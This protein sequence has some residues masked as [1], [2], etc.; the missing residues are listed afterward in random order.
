MA[1]QG[2]PALFVDTG[3]DAPAH[4]NA[5]RLSN[6]SKGVSPRMFAVGTVM[7]GTV[8]VPATPSDAYLMQTDFVQLSFS[9]GS[10]AY[11]FPRAFPNGVATIQLTTVHAGSLGNPLAYSN[12]TLTGFTVWLGTTASPWYISVLAIGW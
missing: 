8:P 11:T 12:I 2:I 3:K 6:W 4:E 1:V 7:V 9:G 10:A 5:R